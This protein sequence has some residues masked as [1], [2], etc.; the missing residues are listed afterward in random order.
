MKKL[1][2]LDRDGVINQ[3]REDSVKSI[4]EFFF[5][6]HAATAIRRINQSGIKVAV[7][8][9]QSVVGRG[10]ITAQH[11]EDI[12]RHMIRELSLQGATIDGI[13]VAP[14][15]PDFATSRRKPGCG[16]VIEAL[17]DFSCTPQDAVFI[18][19]ALRDLQAASSAGCES[20]L[21]RTGRGHR[22]EQEGIPPSIKPI[23]VGEDLLQAAEFILRR[24]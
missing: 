4:A 5:I 9:N 6:P 8:T 10:I 16:M 18:G 19:D 7:A 24:T 17:R 3:D 2:L 1:V 23:Y 13:Y 11:L 15:H 14:D 20:I 22:T 21:V 12:H